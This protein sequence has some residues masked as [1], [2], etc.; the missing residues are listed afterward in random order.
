[1][2]HHYIVDEVYSL[3][4]GERITLSG[5]EGRHAASVSRVRVGE[6]LSI[7][8]GRGLLAQVTVESVGKVDVELLVDS[9]AEMEPQRPAIA[10]V[11]ALAKGDRDERAIEAATELGVTSVIPWQASR[12]VSRWDADK[13]TKGVARWQTIVRE[14]S[15][16]SI[17]S[18][19]PAVAELAS[20]KDVCDLAASSSVLVLAPEGDSQLADIEFVPGREV[21]IVV[22]PEGGITP[23]ELG[24]FRAAGAHLVSLGANI[25]RTSTAGVAAIAALNQ[26]LER[27]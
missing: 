18:W 8:N 14:A 23:E 17:R 7:T 19:I 25:L 6:H 9:V 22:G 5:A 4:T 12:S 2:A 13:A 3:A 10:L 20:T 16:Q 21:I 1:M 26:I 24:Q 11:Q 27:W 15:K